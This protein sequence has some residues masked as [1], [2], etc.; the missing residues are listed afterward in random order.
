MT[1]KKHRHSVC[2]VAGCTKPPY[3][4]AGY[5]KSH[6]VSEV[7][8]KRPG[9]NEKMRALNRTP[10]ARLRLA[11]GCAKRQG[12]EWNISLEQFEE[13]IS[14]K[15]FYCEN[16][17]LAFTGRGL[18]RKDNLKGYTMDNVLPCCGSCNII[19]GDLLTVEETMVVTQALK[20]FRISRG[21]TPYPDISSRWLTR[22]KKFE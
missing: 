2:L 20:A 11:R 16:P 14:M 19:R 12:L 22:K 5:C 4:F 6:Y 18:D 3:P 9:E 10:K 13:L 21:Q 15:C 17:H 7:L 8:R 1:A